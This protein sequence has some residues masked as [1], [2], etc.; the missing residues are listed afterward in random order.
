MRTTPYTLECSC[1]SL[2]ALAAS[3]RDSLEIGDRAKFRARMFEAIDSALFALK[4]SENPTVFGT[5]AEYV[6]DME[7]RDEQ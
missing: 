6:S 7:S 5:D 2:T 1:A 3:A 4:M